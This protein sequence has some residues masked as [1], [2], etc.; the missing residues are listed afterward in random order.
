MIHAF[1]ELAYQRGWKIELDS[2]VYEIYTY[3]IKSQLK[4]PREKFELV[5]DQIIE[6][7]IRGE[8]RKLFKIGK[9]VDSGGYG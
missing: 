4:M 6:L 1:F 9:L 7:D 3:W 5:Q 2:H 8:I